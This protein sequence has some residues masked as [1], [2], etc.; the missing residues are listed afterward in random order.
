MKL[1]PQM[2]LRFHPS[3]IDDLAAQYGYAE[4]MPGSS[5]WENSLLSCRDLLAECPISYAFAR[6]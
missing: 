5:E 4:N 6:T 3:R 2:N 1:S